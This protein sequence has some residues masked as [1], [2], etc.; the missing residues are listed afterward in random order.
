MK[1]KNYSL[2]IIGTLVFL[3]LYMFVINTFSL[4]SFSDISSD[5]LSISNSAD[6][7]IGVSD[8][9]DISVKRERFYGY[10]I[11]NTV[12]NRYSKDLY[13]FRLFKIPLVMNSFQ[14][15]YAHVIVLVLVLVSLVLSS[16]IYFSERRYEK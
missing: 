1:T 10:Y 9:V 11:E 7:K 14:F 2:I 5:D 4:Y 13:L 15:I 3:V 6:I 8:K 16:V 12:G